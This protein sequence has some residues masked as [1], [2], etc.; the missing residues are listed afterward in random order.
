MVRGELV[1]SKQEHPLE[2]AVE[3]RVHED[4]LNALFASSCAVNGWDVM[5]GSAGARFSMSVSG[6]SVYAGT[7]VVTTT[8]C[9]LRCS[10]LISSSDKQRFI[11]YALPGRRSTMEIT[12][13]IRTCQSTAVNELSKT[14]VCVAYQGAFL[15]Y[16]RS[17]KYKWGEE[18]S[19]E[20]IHK[21]HIPRND[22]I[23][24]WDLA[25]KE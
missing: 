21:G 11:H 3:A 1:T 20:E 8:V 19:Q 24:R 7:V 23:Q 13:A 15:E 9:V 16:G 2:I 17:A 5:V 25:Q 22:L 12:T 10:V 14:I 6:E 18:K 4:G